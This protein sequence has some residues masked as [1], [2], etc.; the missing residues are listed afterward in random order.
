MSVFINKN[1][2]FVKLH[3]LP[4]RGSI[5]DI[6]AYLGYHDDQVYTLFG[7]DSSK[8]A[9]DTIVV[10]VFTSNIIFLSYNNDV[11]KVSKK[12]LQV[13]MK[14]FDFNFE[15]NSST[16]QDILLEGIEHKSLPLEFLSRVLGFQYSD[17]NG[18]YYAKKLDIYLFFI[19]GFLA[20]FK[21]S[22]DLN[23]NSR[24]VQSINPDMIADYAKEAQQYWG[25]DYENIYHEV[26]QQSDA[27]VATPKATQNKFVKDHTTEYGNIDF[28]M[29]LVCHYDKKISLS[30]FKHINFGRYTALETKNGISYYSKGNFIYGFKNQSLVSS[31]KHL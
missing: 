30:D 17:V 2:T 11:E 4:N 21:F 6:V 23:K 14:D 7:F 5:N 3:E 22:N 27:L 16:V 20:S 28:F 18:S 26:N 1:G 8:T 19:N 12:D 29:L 24:Y 13:F 31:Q 10:E 9:I 25:H 15:F